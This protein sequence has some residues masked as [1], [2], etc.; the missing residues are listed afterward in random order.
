MTEKTTSCGVI[1]TDGERLLLGHATRSPRWDI[2]KGL[3]EPGESLVA[4]ARRELL[5]ETGLAAPEDELQPLGVFAYRPGKYLALFLWRPAQM[6]DPKALV[7][8]S[9]FAWNGRPLPEFDRFGLFVRDE[10]LAR[11][12]KSMAALLARIP[13][14]ASSGASG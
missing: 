3:A 12:G 7:C 5:E 10:A 1:V 9:Q 6:P 8:A 2:P 13:L 4:A 11:V 14:D